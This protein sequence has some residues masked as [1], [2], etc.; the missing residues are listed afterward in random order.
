M[1]K[2]SEK[3]TILIVEDEELLSE[4]YQEVFQKEGFRVAT[5]K[6]AHEAIGIARAEKPN[7]ILLDILLPG[8]SGIYFLEQRKVHPELA[9]IPVIAFSNFDDLRMKDDAFRL[10]AQDYLLKTNYTPQEIVS[11]VKEYV[12]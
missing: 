12:K 5:A 10:G 11:K 6:T 2:K 7:F 1:P 9:S 4:M 3:K 8:D